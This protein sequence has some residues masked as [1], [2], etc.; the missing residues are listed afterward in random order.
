MADSPISPMVL[1]ILDGWG[2]RDE[3]NGNAISQAKTPIMDSLWNSY[4]RAKINTSGKHVGLPD[5]QM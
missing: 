3:S 4:P 1:V 2:C 5:G